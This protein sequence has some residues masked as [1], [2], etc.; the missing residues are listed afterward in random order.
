MCKIFFLDQ[1]RESCKLQTI[2]DSKNKHRVDKHD[3]FMRNEILHSDYTDEN[4]KHHRYYEDAFMEVI[5][6]IIAYRKL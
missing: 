4:R 1:F 2:Y 3:M 5:I 6:T